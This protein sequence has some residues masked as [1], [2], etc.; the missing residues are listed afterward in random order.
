M[1][2]VDRDGLGWWPDPPADW[3]WDSHEDLQTSDRTK[4]CWWTGNLKADERRRHLVEEY[5]LAPRAKLATTLEAIQNVETTART[6]IRVGD[7]NKANEAL[8]CLGLD[9]INSIQQSEFTGGKPLEMRALLPFLVPNPCSE[10]LGD[11]PPDLLGALQNYMVTIY[12]KLKAEIDQ[13]Q[14]GWTSSQA[15]VVKVIAE[16]FKQATDVVAAEQAIER[17]KDQGKVRLIGVVAFIVASGAIYFIWSG[18]RG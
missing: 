17:E 8:K 4:W 7:F 13:A 6:A 9:R 18:K 1:L 14:A 5:Y 3:V 11:P 16:Q 15:Q 12:S 10:R 2:A